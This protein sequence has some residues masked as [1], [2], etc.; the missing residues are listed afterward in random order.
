MRRT[1][2]VP[3]YFLLHAALRK[4]FTRAT[5]V[6]QTPWRTTC[7]RTC[8]E[9]TFDTERCNDVC[10]T[11][12]YKELFC[13]I[14]VLRKL[15]LEYVNPFF[16]GDKKSPSADLGGS[17]KY[18]NKNFEGWRGGR[19]TCEQQLDMGIIVSFVSW[20]WYCRIFCISLSHIVCIIWTPLYY[21]YHLDPPRCYLYH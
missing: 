9:D 15:F 12:V 8:K 4:A 5:F 11:L 2:R 7:D 14:S 13:R 6:Q 3:S 17:N 21:L 20:T 16:V 19:A 10:I 18:S 1:H